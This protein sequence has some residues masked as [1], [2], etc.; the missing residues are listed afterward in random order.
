[1]Q[2]T[3]DQTEAWVIGT[4]GDVFNPQRV[5]EAN[6]FTTSLYEGQVALSCNANFETVPQ[7]AVEQYPVE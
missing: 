2:A 3:L 4:A 7:D 6:T 5:F 1:M